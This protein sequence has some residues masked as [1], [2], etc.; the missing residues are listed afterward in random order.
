MRFFSLLLFL[1][2]SSI[3]NVS[4]ACNVAENVCLIFEQDSKQTTISHIPESIASQEY[5]SYSI[6]NASFS[7]K[8]SPFADFIEFNEYKEVKD[9]PNPSS[10]SIFLSYKNHFSYSNHKTLKSFLYR[11]ANNSDIF[12]FVSKQILYHI[13]L[14]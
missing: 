4:G 1:L 10:R 7:N 9:N 12:P 13:F 6:V 8:I 14:I 5:P 11:F 3:F 2:T